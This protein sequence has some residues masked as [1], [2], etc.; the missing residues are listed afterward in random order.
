MTIKFYFWFL[1][2]TAALKAFPDVKL[3][4]FPRI[5]HCW[6]LMTNFADPHAESVVK[7]KYMHANLNVWIKSLRY[8]K[9]VYFGCCENFGRL[10]YGKKG[11]ILNTGVW[12]A[13]Q[14][15]QTSFYFQEEMPR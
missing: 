13:V 4:D 11:A 3:N 2:P 6:W 5:E 14:D 1:L 7:S 15:A 8:H 12:R 9:P 10:Y